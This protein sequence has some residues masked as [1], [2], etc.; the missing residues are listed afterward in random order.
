VPDRL[1][2]HLE[3]WRDRAAEARVRA[4][5]LEDPG[6]RQTAL[7]V[8]AGYGRLCIEAERI[9]GLKARLKQTVRRKA[10]GQP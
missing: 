7:E 10:F 5:A 8:A 6:A 4:E 9:L 2:D 1:G 3:Y